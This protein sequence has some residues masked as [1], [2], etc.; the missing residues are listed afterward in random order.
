MLI[1]RLLTDTGKVRQHNEDDAGIFEAKE[2]S[3]LAVV[4]DGMEVILLVM[5]PARW[6][7]L[8]L[9]EYWEETSSIPEKPAD[10][11]SW[12]ISKNQ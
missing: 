9:K 4:A 11:E 7:S 10:Q 6:Q 1:R 3:L 5:S 12:L 8:S 2:D